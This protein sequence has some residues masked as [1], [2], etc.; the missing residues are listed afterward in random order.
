[1]ASSD[2]NTETESEREGISK[3]ASVKKDNSSSSSSGS[4]SDDE[5]I[6]VDLK[7]DKSRLKQD[8]SAADEDDDELIYKRDMFERRLG[9]SNLG[10]SCY[11]NCIIQILAHLTQFKDQLSKQLSLPDLEDLV[12]KFAQNSD[13]GPG[14]EATTSAPSSYEKG[15]NLVLDENSPKQIEPEPLPDVA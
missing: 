9:L 6:K 1:M 15:D 10:N 11:M 5:E 2:S 13:S 3:K 12:L 4:E 7:E 8:E 14:S